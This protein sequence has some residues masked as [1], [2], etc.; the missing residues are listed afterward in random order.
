MNLLQET[1]DALKENGKTPADVRWVGRAS[2]SAKC[3]WEDFAKQANFEYDNGYGGAEIPKDLVAVGDDWWLERYEYDGAEWWELK[4]IPAEPKWDS[5]A[6]SRDLGIG[7]IDRLRIK[8]GYGSDYYELLVAPCGDKFRA[9]GIYKQKGVNCP[10]QGSADSQVRDFYV[11]ALTI[12]ASDFLDLIG[13]RCEFAFTTRGKGEAFTEVF[14][15]AV[16]TVSFFD[17]N[18]VKLT[19][20][21]LAEIK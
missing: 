5:H 10:F 11:R 13:K 3:A 9:K 2:I 16:R 17:G 7:K 19:V 12:R 20:E 18:V 8:N 1:L 6:F 4:T 15:G 14:V 21:V